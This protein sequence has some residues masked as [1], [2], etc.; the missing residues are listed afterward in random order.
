MSIKLE[1][2]RIFITGAGGLLGKT[3]IKS[4]LESGAEVIATELPGK[5]SQDL[6]DE[7]GNKNTLESDLVLTSGEQVTIGLLS[8]ALKN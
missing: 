6:I 2:K 1:G 7:F 5:R 8:L 3:Y 4:M